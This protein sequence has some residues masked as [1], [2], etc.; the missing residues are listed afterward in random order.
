MTAILEGPE[1]TDA[2]RFDL[3]FYVGPKSL[4]DLRL[5]DSRLE[6]LLSFGWLSWIA[7]ILLQ[8]LQLIYQHVGNYGL[9]II[10]LTLLLRIVIAPIFI[11]KLT[12]HMAIQR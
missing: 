2:V 8:L 1:L 10:L 6:D 11:E 4:K 3:S 12:A 7:K 9:A 5:V